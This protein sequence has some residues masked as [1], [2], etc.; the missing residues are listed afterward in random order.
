MPLALRP[1]LSGAAL[2]RESIGCSDAQTY[3]VERDGGYV[4]KIAAPGA[5]ARAAAMTRFLHGH[6]L[7]ARVVAYASE[8]QD[9]LLTERLPGESCI[10]A[11]YLAEP[12]RLC[13]AL[14]ESLL[15]LHALPSDGCPLRAQTGLS[16]DAPTPYDVVLHGDAC[17]PNVLLNDWAFS[18][19]VDLGDGGVGDRHVDIYWVL[20][21]MQYNLKSDAYRGRFLDAYGRSFLDDERLRLVTAAIPSLP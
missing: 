6:G 9:W 7:A 10:A 12:E 19:F 20:W 13:D 8:A 16:D 5:L 4:L 18:G 15:R 1:Y 3:Y 2:L 17:L 21:S 14:A 11:R